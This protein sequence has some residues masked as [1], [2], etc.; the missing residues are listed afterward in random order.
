MWEDPFKAR[1][2]C[3]VTVVVGCIISKPEIVQAMTK[4]LV[5][6]YVRLPVP[7]KQVLVIDHFLVV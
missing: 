6:C 1:Y 7:K 3:L 2:E 5:G 4:Q